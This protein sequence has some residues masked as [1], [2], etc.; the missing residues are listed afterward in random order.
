MVY[1]IDVSGWQENIRWTEV[2][3]SQ[4]Q[5]VFAKATEGLHA[6]N[7]QFHKQHDGA[8]RS[9]IPFGTYHYIDVRE[10]G[11][12]QA[13]HFLAAISGYEGTLLPAVDVE[14]THGLSPERIVT[15]LA[16]FLKAVD[17]TLKGKRALFYTNRSFWNDTMV[18]RDDLSGHPLWIAQYPKH[19]R[20]GMQPAIPRGWKGAVI[21]QFTQSARVNGVSGVVDMDQLIG[22][23]IS[24]ISR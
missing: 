3:K 1:G 14:E 15:C 12:G 17:A 8:E 9:G 6:H 11:A 7:D 2:P 20:P 4:V 10:G 16:E 23:D 22:D 18:G 24:T 21:W 5:F 19:Y 13:K